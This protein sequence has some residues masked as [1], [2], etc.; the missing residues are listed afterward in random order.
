MTPLDCLRV[1]KQATADELAAVLCLP[2]AVVLKQLQQARDE[3][4]AVLDVQVQ[5]FRR[6]VEMW[7]ATA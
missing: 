1:V 2:R 7:R 3:R 6:P 5:M 4:K